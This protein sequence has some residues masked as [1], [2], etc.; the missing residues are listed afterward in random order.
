MAFGFK[1]N[2]V[3]GYTDAGGG[4]TGATVNHLSYDEFLARKK[5]LREA[6]E[7]KRAAE[8]NAQI[9]R[10]IDPRP[11]AGASLETVAS[12]PKPNVEMWP[13]RARDGASLFPAAPDANAGVWPSRVQAGASLRTVASPPDPNAGM[14]PTRAQDGASLFTAAPKPEDR[15]PPLSLEPQAGASLETV[16][17]WADTG[18]DIWP[19]RVQAGASLETAM[20]VPYADKTRTTNERFIEDYH[21]INQE[22]DTLQEYEADMMIIGIN[23]NVLNDFASYYEDS[24]WLH[25]IDPDEAYQR[26]M[27]QTNALQA[28]WE[29]FTPDMTSEEKRQLAEKLAKTNKEY[30][31]DPEKFVWMQKIREIDDYHLVTAEMMQLAD[32]IAHTT[33]L[34]LLKTL[35]G[36]LNWLKSYAASDFQEG[37]RDWIAKQNDEA[38]VALRTRDDYQAEYNAAAAEWENPQGEFTQDDIDRINDKFDDDINNT[39]G[40]EYLADQKTRTELEDM[41]VNAMI[42]I[43][44]FDELPDIEKIGINKEDIEIEMEEYE[45]L[46]EAIDKKW[47]GYLDSDDWVLFQRLVK[48]KE[49]FNKNPNEFEKLM[50]P[51]NYRYLADLP[52]EINTL[53]NIVSNIRVNAQNYLISLNAE[54]GYSDIKRKPDFY[55]IPE[56]MYIFIDN[57]QSIRTQLKDSEYYKYMSDDEKQTAN[58]IAYHQGEKEAEFYVEKYLIP[59]L[60][61]R[62]YDEE[63]AKLNGDDLTFAEGTIRY[64]TAF[65]SQFVNSAKAT[66]ARG[67]QKIGNFFGEDDYQPP[68]DLYNAAAMKTK[69]AD[70]SIDSIKSQLDDIHLYSAMFGDHTAGDALMLG[71]DLLKTAAGWGTTKL[72]GSGAATALSF[73]QGHDKAYQEAV[74][75]HA[76]ESDAWDYATWTSATELLLNKITTNDI[77]KV[78]SPDDIIKIL[79]DKGVKN[80]KKKFVVMF[81][82]N[83]FDMIINQEHSEFSNRVDAYKEMYDDNEAVRKAI[84]DG[85]LEN[86]AD[87]GQSYYRG[88]EK[89]GL[90]MIFTR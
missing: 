87:L 88:V 73:L 12:P 5:R 20:D 4:A 79:A 23:Q 76:S 39:L 18:A 81:A 46:I 55:D 83:L 13:T 7:K 19:S 52:S 51:E 62:K 53:N 68:L 10:A 28:K 56:T 67:Q 90:D 47:D 40:F 43:D 38:E 86:A 34:H 11:Q 42:R 48:G 30:N 44:K 70:E 14:W 77:S 66:V 37:S 82:N 45:S 26:L 65:A 58:Y 80:V 8:K 21:R 9:L 33:D 69:L 16:A 74:N 89:G 78:Q 54:Y 59:S 6:A 31:E 71:T 57:P 24:T 27:E 61:Q 29:G 75:N 49:E 63:S 64:L 84:V 85:I 50:L 36:K 35:R 60:I 3:A 25:E 2:E 22:A 1:K 72:V 32:Q 15:K 17:S 41:R